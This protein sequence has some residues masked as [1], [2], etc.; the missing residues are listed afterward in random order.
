LLRNG[1]EKDLERA[2]GSPEGS[3]NFLQCWLDFTSSFV[4][5]LSLSFVVRSYNLIFKQTKK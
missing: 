1:F 3:S 4:S 2:Q 5:D